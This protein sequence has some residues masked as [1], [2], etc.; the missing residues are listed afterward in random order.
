M[1]AQ[2]D[3]VFGFV[4]PAIRGIQ[5]RREYYVSMYP[6]RLIPK[7]F[8]YDDAE[9]PPELRAQRTLNKSRVPEMARYML[10]NPDDYVFSALTVSIDAEVRFEPIGRSGEVSRVG[11]LHVPMDAKFIIN[12]GQHRR[13]AIEQALR[14]HPDI[15]D[16]SIAV[17]FFLDLGLQRCQQMFAD[18]NRYA[19]RPN[20]SISVL[21][22]HRDDKAKL[23]KLI[24]LKSD[25][26]RD[27]VDLERNTLA[28]RARK[29][30]T[31]SAI[32]QANT[33]LLD[34]L[35]LGSREEAARVATE[36]WL[37]AA[38]CFP[39]WDLV[40]TRK[41]AAGEVRENF[42]HSHGIVLQAL[43][44]VGNILL[45]D[46]PKGWKKRMFALPKINWARTN[47]SL[48]EGRAMVGGQVQKGTQNVVLTVNAIKEHLGLALGPEE[49][50]VEDAFS[51]RK[52]G[53]RK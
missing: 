36:F 22:D 19:I 6:L 10:D 49:Q 25:F 13:A 46:H 12:D 34:K 21:Y 27:I 51:R 18:L 26:F 1:I 41:M 53:R 17:V 29:L 28:P 14:D 52:N 9:M 24:V 20:R 39:E 8:R 45:R 30:F 40:R 7:L 31:L 43:G 42:I 44:R 50:R 16:E 33:D 48:W 11:L 38:R 15:G 3:T 23:A 2:Q 4:F 5:A 37:E 35:E 47:S 32:Y